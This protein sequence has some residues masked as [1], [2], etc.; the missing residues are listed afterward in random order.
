[1]DDPGS[2]EP[3]N[4]ISYNSLFDK[5][6]NEI[7]IIVTYYMFTSLST[8]GFGDYNPRSDFERVFIAFVLLFAHQT[9][10]SLLHTDFS[11]INNKFIRDTHAI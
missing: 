4:F 9:A 7:T 6:P 8:V 5:S 11:A 3:E 10:T 1:M 2:Y